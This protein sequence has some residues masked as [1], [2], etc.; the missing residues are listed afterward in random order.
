V[1][2]DDAPAQPLPH[3]PQVRAFVAERRG[4]LVEELSAWLRI[5]SISAD[6]DH[7]G[8]VSRSA[9]WLAQRLLRAG[10]PT[11]EIWS[12]PGLPSVYAEWPSG[13]PDAPTV[14]LYGHHD[15]QPVDPVELWET[16]PFEPL[17]RTTEHGEE[18]V[19][20]GA[21]DDKG[22]VYLHVVGL[23]AHL[24]TTVRSAPAVNLKVIVEG[25]EE[26]GSVHFGAL[27]A[28]NRE[29]LRCDV[30][31][32]SDTGVYGRDTISV[33]VG[34][35]G[36]VEVQ[37]DVR[38]PSGDLHSGSFGGAVPNPVTTLARVV[39]RLHDAQ[40]HVTLPG[41]YDK[42]VPL[43]ERERELLALLP[44]DEARWLADARSSATYGEAGFTTLER[45]GARPTAEVNGIWGGYTGPGGKTIVPSEAHVKL[46]FRLVPGQ[47]PADVRPACEAWLE[48]LRADGTIPSGIEVTA[49]Y[50]RAGV[51]PCLTPVDHPALASVRRSLGR[52]FG[53]EVLVTREGGSGPEADLADILEV[54]V[55]FLGVGLPDDRI[56]A[57]NEKADIEFLLAGAEAAAYLWTDLATTWE[58]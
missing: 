7:A 36:L 37:L 57:P 54:P 4:Q 9:D 20:R 6:P 46:S 44:F 56:H 19:G 17:V 58:R 42:V 13:E 21:I 40:G 50:D 10:F 12:T 22:Q 5:P 25:E 28:E 48:Q 51:R 33:C 8:D 30:V 15:V 2:L 18:L 24:A 45:V 53:T 23:A 11:V 49:R 16:S 34:M 1:I 3:D 39:A 32:V 14:L 52:A 35:R 47:D 55:V 29:R 27:L 38:G 31:V 41:Y 43:T 26:S